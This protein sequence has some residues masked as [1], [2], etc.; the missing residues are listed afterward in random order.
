MEKEIFEKIKSEVLEYVH[1]LRLSAKSIA[2]IDCLS[3]LTK[4]AAENGYIRPSFNDENRISIVD[5]KHPIV[6]AMIDDQFIPNDTNL[7]DKESLWVI[8]GP[9]MGGKSTY[10]RQVALISLLAQIGSF[11]PARNANLSI[12]DRIFTRIGA[13]DHLAQGKSTFLVEMEETA[14]ICLQATKRSLVIL[15]EVGRGTSTYD[16]LALA[17]AVVEYIVHKVGA[18]CLFA[19]H[20][21]ELTALQD[22][23]NGIVSYYMDS[24]KSRSG[25]LFLHKLVRGVA[26]G[27]F[28]IEVAKLAQLP[29]PLID[30]AKVILEGLHQQ[31]IG[32]SHKPVAPQAF[33]PAVEEAVD[34]ELIE[35]LKDLDVDSMTP[36]Q[37]LQELW[38]LKDLA[39]K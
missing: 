5:G 19:T 25:I 15:D 7:S 8:T 29:I 34:S 16:G 10:L 4:V 30:R 18:R 1:Q 11:V 13:G 14:Q 17:Q 33:I 24:Q 22:M 9:N 38:D 3:G 31:N 35:K 21:H 6:A 20:Y 36:R 23:Y 32:T 37:A 26:D 2:I 12:L 39:E 28:G 27:S